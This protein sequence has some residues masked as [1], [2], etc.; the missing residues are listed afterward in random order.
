M[1]LNLI[2]P[3]VEVSRHNTLQK[4]LYIVQECSLFINSA[5]AANVLEKKLHKVKEVELHVKYLPAALPKA[6][7]MNKL[8]LQDIP[9]EVDDDYLHLFT[10]NCLKLS[11]SDFSMSRSKDKALLTFTKERTISGK[12]CD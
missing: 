8:I 1:F 6:C 9:A 4:V 11:D 7:E 3:D 2:T 10:E 5:A 12:S